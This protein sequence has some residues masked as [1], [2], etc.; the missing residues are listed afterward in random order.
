MIF[1]QKIDTCRLLLCVLLMFLGACQNLPQR[2]H[3]S[4]EQIAALKAEGFEQSDDGWAFSASDKLLFGSNESVLIPSARQVTN[5]LGHLLV[6]L[7]IER[8]R[9]DGHTDTTGSVSYNEQLSLRRAAAVSDALVA[10]GVNAKSI[11]VRGLGQT[12][13]VASNQTAE[14][15]LQNRRVVIVIVSD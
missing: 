5:R 4:Q 3:L 9:V 8:I 14:G 6:S 12:A 10:A 15:R 7:Q 11:Q 2:Q 1:Q 13:P